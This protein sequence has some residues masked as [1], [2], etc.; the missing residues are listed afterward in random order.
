MD[1]S[2]FRDDLRLRFFLCEHMVHGLERED[3]REEPD[4]CREAGSDTEQAAECEK[5]KTANE[6]SH[7][8][9]PVLDSVS[10]L[11]QIA[12]HAR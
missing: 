9:L 5:Q 1:E 10:A 7:R 11:K 4:A 6:A 3:V 2:A 12:T 8:L